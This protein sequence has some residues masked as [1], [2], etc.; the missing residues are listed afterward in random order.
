M[1]PHARTARSGTSPA[2]ASRGFSLIEL[3]VVVVVIAL[4]LGVILSVSRN[5]LGDAQRTQT[6]R[7]LASIGQGLEQFYADHGYY[8][9]LLNENETKGSWTPGTPDPDRLAVA[10]RPS[11]PPDP[12]SSDVRDSSNSGPALPDADEEDRAYFN[13][14]SLPIYLLG[15]GDLS[16]DGPDTPDPSDHNEDDGVDGPGLRSP[17]DD[18]S[19]GGSRDRRPHEDG[20]GQ[21]PPREGRVYGPYVDLGSS[22]GA[23]KSI[24]EGTTVPEF[25]PYV[26]LFRIVDRWG[27]PIRYYRGWPMRDSNGERTMEYTPNEIRDP[28]K[29]EAALSGPGTFADRMRALDSELV[30]APFVLLSVGPD[31][32]S[33]HRTPDDL[34]SLDVEQVNDVLEEVSDN[35]R[36]VP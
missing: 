18:K 24:V 8:P 11:I 10:D 25:E 14:Y 3:L 4:L 20:G 35:V 36:H 15:V 22:D 12:T 19:W 17:G 9:P 32:F 2:P 34:S 27:S 23:L 7:L 1:T 13:V 16:G 21:D 33:G 28:E 29:L 30:D 5:V 26:G 6:E 31:G